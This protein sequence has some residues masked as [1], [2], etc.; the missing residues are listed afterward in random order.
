[1]PGMKGIK[2]LSLD[3]NDLTTLPES[4]GQLTDLEEFYLANNNFTTLPESLGQLTNLQG[5]Y[6]TNNPNLTTLPGTLVN[7]KNLRQLAIRRTG[8]H[9]LSL[10]LPLLSVVQPHFELLCD[11]TQHDIFSK[12]PTLQQWIQE[13]KFRWIDNGGG[14]WMLQKLTN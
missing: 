1:M 10:T 13:G 9:D 2:N 3:N 6:L 4:L 5:L 7:L 8:I 14:Q 12:D 11:K